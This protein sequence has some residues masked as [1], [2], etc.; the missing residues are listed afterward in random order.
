[1]LERDNSQSAITKAFDL[2]SYGTVLRPGEQTVTYEIMPEFRQKLYTDPDFLTYLCSLDERN[3]STWFPRIDEEGYIYPS[4]FIGPKLPINEVYIEDIFPQS[5]TWSLRHF[6]SLKE[7]YGTPRTPDEMKECSDDF[8]ERAGG[9]VS[10]YFKLLGDI[11]SATPVQKAFEIMKNLRGRDTRRTGELA[12]CHDVRSTLRFMVEPLYSLSQDKRLRYH[13]EL[14]STS[15][16]G[17]AFHDFFED[18][19]LEGKGSFEYLENFIL[20]QNNDSFNPYVASIR[21]NSLGPPWVIFRE[22]VNLTNTY[23]HKKSRKSNDFWYGLK[24][25]AKLLEDAGRDG[26]DF[27]FIRWSVLT[28]KCMDRCDNLDTLDSYSFYRYN[29]KLHETKY[30]HPLSF[31]PWTSHMAGAPKPAGQN[32]LMLLGASYD[33]MYGWIQDPDKYAAKEIY[34]ILEEKGQSPLVIPDIFHPVLMAKGGT[35]YLFDRNDPDSVTE[36]CIE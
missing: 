36:F 35:F 28:G 7:H 16:C 23:D 15:A 5:Q 18:I 8:L 25:L 22:A 30:F 17:I 21:F 1:M 2:D 11:D 33:E 4:F 14:Y 13:P 19:E 6:F 3:L 26:D 29:N 24:N 31:F 9:V 32:L 10:E 34:D 20:I 27:P 12:V